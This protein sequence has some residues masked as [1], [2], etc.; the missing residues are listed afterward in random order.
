[1]RGETLKIKQKSQSP[2]E[3]DWAPQWEILT[4]TDASNKKG[5]V[6]GSQF[7]GHLTK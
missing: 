2:M 5:L 6:L 3:A 7:L 4:T 1:M